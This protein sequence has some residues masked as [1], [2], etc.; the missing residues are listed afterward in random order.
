MFTFDHVHLRSADPEATAAFYEHMFGA[1]IIRT[2]QNGTPRID[3]KLGGTDIFI[4]N[5]PPDK[6]APAPSAPYFGIDHFG[7]SVTDIDAVAADLKTTGAHFT[8]DPN[9]IRPGIRIA[10][11]RGPE[12]V[13]IELLE[14]S[15]T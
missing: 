9:T 13:S 5:T 8:L 7:L 10:F 4:L 11:L 2:T 6:A 14:R 15:P 1:Q 12:G 3:M